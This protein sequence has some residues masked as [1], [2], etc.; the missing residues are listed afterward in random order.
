VSVSWAFIPGRPSHQA[1]DSGEIRHTWRRKKLRQH[2]ASNGA[3]YVHIAGTTLL[4]HHLI[5]TAFTG[6]PLTRGYRAVQVNGD[7]SDNRL[8]NLAWSGRT[9]KTK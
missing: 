7:K 4:V 8:D 5:L 2:L 3:R 6:H 9:P 1:S